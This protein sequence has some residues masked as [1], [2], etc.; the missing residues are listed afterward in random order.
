MSI[1]LSLIVPNK[2]RSLRDKGHAKK[3]FDEMIEQII[4]Y[5]GGRKQFVTGITI[6]RYESPDEESDIFEDIEYSFEIPILSTT[7]F[8]RS[9][10]WK[11]GLTQ[12]IVHIFI[13]TLLIKTDYQEYGVEKFASTYCW[14]LDAKKDGFVM[15]IIVGTA[16]LITRFPPLKIGR[17]ME[18]LQRIVPSMNLM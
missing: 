2:C 17:L 1:D 16:T 5:F 8:M 10:Y 12:N 13:L 3:C 14:Y 4:K 7:V 15:N 18:K 11:Y 9:G 6:K